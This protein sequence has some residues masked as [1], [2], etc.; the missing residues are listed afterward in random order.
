MNLSV[1]G[2][3]MGCEIMVM[4]QVSGESLGWQP[5]VGS[6]L[7]A[8]QNSKVSIATRKK[9]YSGRYTLHRQSAGHLGS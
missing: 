2:K 5:S 7:F 3:K 1:S 6:W 9:V 8:G 4:S